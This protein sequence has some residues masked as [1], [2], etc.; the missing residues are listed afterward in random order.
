VK[1]THVV[2][3]IEHI[4]EG[5]GDMV[6]AMASQMHQSSDGLVESLILLQYTD[7]YTS[8]AWKLST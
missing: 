8:I 6:Q 1:F 3:F 7:G 5:H 4:T 2:H